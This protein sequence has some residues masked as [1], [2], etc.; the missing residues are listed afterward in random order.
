MY[1]PFPAKDQN[2]PN[3]PVR[4][5]VEIQN[6]FKSNTNGSKYQSCNWTLFKAQF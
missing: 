6:Q 5:T 3:F 4:Q 1:H 2:N